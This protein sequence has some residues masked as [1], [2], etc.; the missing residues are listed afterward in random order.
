MF[1]GYPICQKGKNFHLD[2][3]D[4]IANK[5]RLCASLCDR[6]GLPVFPGLPDVHSQ[7]TRGGNPPGSRAQVGRLADHSCWYTRCPV[8]SERYLMNR[9]VMCGVAGM[10]LL[11]AF[12]MSSVDSG[13]SAHAG[14]FKRLLGKK[15][16]D[17]CAPVDCCAPAAPACCTPAPAPCCE[18]VVT[19]CAPVD[20][21]AVTCGGETKKRKGLFARL[22]ERRAAKKAAASC[23]AP[24]PTCCEPAPVCCEPVT[25]CAP[26][27]TC[28]EAAPAPCCGG[29]VVSGAVM[30]G[31]VIISESVVEPVADSASDAEAA[32]EE[33][34]P[35]T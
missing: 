33:A 21:C 6:Q 15:N 30:G 8:Y 34:P 13:N 24:A 16:A 7:S 32:T 23:C 28:C 5:D 17:C 27:P 9:S 22:R 18:P 26:A 11:F 25:C 19:C 1:P 31:E 2:R 20:P 14:L 4:R 35:E 10:A 29:T 12:A 3:I